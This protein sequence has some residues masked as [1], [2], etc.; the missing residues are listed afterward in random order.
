[1]LAVALPH[2]VAKVAAD[3]AAVSDGVRMLMTAAAVRQRV[4]LVV[5]PELWVPVQSLIRLIL[6]GLIPVMLRLVVLVVLLAWLALS[7]KRLW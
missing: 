6:V 5:M 4:L 7:V 2:A 3:A 1:M